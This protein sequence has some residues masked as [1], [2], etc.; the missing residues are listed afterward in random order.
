MKKLTGS[1]LFESIGY[2]NEDYIL[3]ASPYE[4]RKLSAS[5]RRRQ[6]FIRTAAVA[7]CVCLL[8]IGVF[9]ARMKFG[10]SDAPTQNGGNAAMLEGDSTDV[11]SQD[12]NG[13][14]VIDAGFEITDGVSLSYCGEGV[15]IYVPASVKTVSKATFTSYSDAPKVTSLTLTSSETKLEEGALAPLTS[16]ESVI[17]S[18]GTGSGVDLASL[19]DMTVTDIV[20]SGLSI[21]LSYV[22][23]TPVEARYGGSPVYALGELNGI[24]LLFNSFDLTDYS[25]M[26]SPLSEAAK[27][28]SVYVTDKASQDVTVAP[29]LYI[30]MDISESIEL[31]CEFHEVEKE[32]DSGH[33]TMKYWFGGY[34][35]HVCLDDIPDELC[36]ALLPWS[37]DGTS[38]PSE[39]EIEACFKLRDEFA[40]APVGKIAKIEVFKAIDLD[41]PSQPMIV[42]DGTG[43]GVDLASLLDMTFPD[44]VN[45]GFSIQYEYTRWGGAPI[46]SVRR[47]EGIELEFTS[48]DTVDG[49]A[50][51]PLLESVKPWSVYITDKAP[52]SITVAPG[53][54]VG[55]DISTVDADEYHFELLGEDFE[56]GMLVM[57]YDYGGTYIEGEG[58]LLDKNRYTVK[59]YLSDVPEELYKELFWWHNTD[60][61]YEAT[62]GAD[63]PSVPTIP[64]EIVDSLPEGSGSQRGKRIDEFE[65]APIGKVSKIEVRPCHE[66]SWM[67]THPFIERSEE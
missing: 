16:L 29:G 36:H 4:M 27:P 23:G 37:T 17:V 67:H 42:T 59:V 10:G 41:A 19:L 52:Q 31:G 45:N 7:A 8:V 56:S 15:E 22:D 18:D 9:C 14:T 65:Q 5:R 46:Y 63:Y 49:D 54:Y 28:Y 21:S 6:A 43:S 3:E 50:L 62:M 58:Y 33:I 38:Q 66:H 35:I 13:A 55:M 60:Y 44:I 61:D 53:L 30:G 11:P 25:D 57:C 34:E 26:Q 48:S 64:E 1:V 24:E 40:L 39:E 2:I 12:G 20:N 32:L 47:F 51:S